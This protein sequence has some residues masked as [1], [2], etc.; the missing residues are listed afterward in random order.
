ML[1]DSS[2]NEEVILKL[3]F[4]SFAQRGF[5]FSRGEVKDLAA[6]EM[7]KTA[8]N[9]CFQKKENKEAMLH[10]NA[11]ILKCPLD[12][13]DGR[14]L[15]AVLTANRSAVLFE[16]Q[17]YEK[18][19][20]DIAT[21]E[22]MG[23]YPANLRYKLTY[24]RAKCYEA[25]SQFERA[26]EAFDEALASL[27]GECSLGEGERAR[28]ANIIK[29]S[30]AQKVAKNRKITRIANMLED[31]TNFQGS[32][33]YPALS[34]LVDIVVHPE[35]GRYAAAKKDI[36]IGTVILKEEAI[37]SVTLESHHKTHC[38]HCIVSVDQPFPCPTCA[39]VLFCSEDCRQ[40]AMSSYHGLE[41]SVFGS[42]NECGTNTYLVLRL[43]IQRGYSYFKDRKDRL[44]E[45]LNDESACTELTKKEVY[46]SD[47]Y[48]NVLNLYKSD[49]QDGFNVYVYSSASFLLFALRKMQFFPFQTDENSFHDD[50]MFIGRLLLR[51]CRMVNYNVHGMGEITPLPQRVIL[52]NGLESYYKMA[53]TGV[54]LFPTYAF[55]N[56]SCDPSLVRCNVN[57]T[58]FVRT[59]KPIKAGDPVYDNY[60]QHY[61]WTK[62][63]D[64]QKKL[65]EDY[66]FKCA[67]IAC[68]EKWPL[69]EDMEAVVNV[70]CRYRH[71]RR[72]IAVTK[73]NPNPQRC[74]FCH[75][76]LAPDAISSIT[77]AIFKFLGFADAPFKGRRFEEA[78]KLYIRVLMLMYRHASKPDLDIIKIQELI[79]CCQQQF[80]NKACEYFYQQE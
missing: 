55:F 47:D 68:E 74:T 34:P 73:A 79:E 46:L 39:N 65:L 4:K 40:I 17:E 45:T 67:C 12:T 61:L 52:R 16:L 31:I 56:H 62:F 64:R 41:C 33:K 42:L 22:E 71:C 9:V 6:A 75:R 14:K 23:T 77:G 78:L 76:R 2:D 51:H 49:G 29:T 58:V 72:V 21:I 37:V 30:K 38:Y 48:E 69:V 3:A 13:D 53:R 15:M 36:P 26:D 27:M 63:E 59:I 19:I 20:K 11:G 5:N 1:I 44:L 57:R 50:E 70:P 18:V 54:A 10:Y 32:A 25:L 8:G 43:I 66:N 24:R 80:G 28:R 7:K 60:G 35:K